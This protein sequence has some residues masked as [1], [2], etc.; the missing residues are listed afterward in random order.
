MSLIQQVFGNSP[1]QPLVEHA[2]KV[3][4]CV[5]LVR[6][7][8]QAVVDSDYEEVHRLQ[9]QVSKL[10]YEADQ[11][12]HRIREQLPRRFFLPVSREDL[13][14]FLHCQDNIADGVEDFAVILVI[15]KTA[16]HPRLVP[17][18]MEIVGQVV[19]VSETMYGAAAELISLAETSFE[20]AEATRI[21]DLIS[22]LG[23]EEW[24]ADRLQRKLSQQVYEMEDELDPVTISFYEKMQRALSQ[25]ADAAEN[26]GDML[27]AMIVKG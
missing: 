16:V 10:E 4:E 17:A 25:I 26:T 14:R 12:K 8:M 9:D 15:R 13:D 7:L 2:G 21:L 20:G 6:P 19:Q 23:E 1:F 11:I 18:F 24:K 27:R 22:T 3:H 5:E